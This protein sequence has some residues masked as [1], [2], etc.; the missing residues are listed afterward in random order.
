MIGKGKIKGDSRVVLGF[1]PERL[2]EDGTAAPTDTT[3][4]ESL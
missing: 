2:A 4:V 1:L 3:G